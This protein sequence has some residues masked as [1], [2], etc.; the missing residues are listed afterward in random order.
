M[1]SPKSAWSEQ[2]TQACLGRWRVQEALSAAASHALASGAP[3]PLLAMADAL[4][5]L[6]LAASA[7]SVGINGFGR[8]LRACLRTR[9]ARVVAINDPFLTAEDMADLLRH[10]S[11]QG[12]FEGG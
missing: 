3:D 7:P 10:D 11:A 8:M 2:E 5:D 4:R 1:A 9:K 6:S 12:P